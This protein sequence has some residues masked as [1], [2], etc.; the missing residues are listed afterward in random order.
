MTL[1]ELE[2]DLAEA[3]KGGQSDRLRVLRLI[4]TGLQNEAIKQGRELNEDEIMRVV[5]HEA[6]QRRDSIEAYTK[7][8]RD[9]LAAAE[10]AELEIIQSYLPQALSEAELAELV[11]QA[12]AK[13]GAS[14]Q[15]RT[16][17]VIGAVMAAAGGRADGALVARLVRQ[18]L[19]S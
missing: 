17:A 7:A 14:D 19:A 16:G 15:G 8:G 3:L 11:E 9:D 18:R 1:V 12:I 6:K 5:A 10:S 2:G 13:T 4:K